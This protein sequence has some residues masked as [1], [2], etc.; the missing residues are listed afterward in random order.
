MRRLV[1]IISLLTAMF[2]MIVPL[3]AEGKDENVYVIPI[4]DEIEKALHV[5]LERAINEAEQNEADVIVFDVKTP[6]GEISAAMDIGQLIRNTDIKTVTFVN[7]RAISAG[8]YIALNTDEIYMTPS[9]VMGAAAPIKSDGSTADKKAVSMWLAAMEGAAKLNDRDP[10]YAKAMVIKDVDLPELKKKDDLLTL[11][12][13]AAE[14]VGYS[15]GTFNN[16]DDLLTHLGYDQASIQTVNLTFAEKLARFIANP[17][18][19]PILLSIAS[20]GLVV[21]LYSPGFGIAGG[22]GLSALILFFF[23]HY[24]AGVAGYEAIILFV[25]GV[26]LIIAEAFLPGGVAGLLGAAAVIGSIIMAGGNIA[27]YAT[28]VVIALFLTSIFIIIM[29]K[30]FGKRMNF[31]KRFILTDATDTESGYVSNVNRTELLNQEGIT[32]TALRP[33]GT[34]KIGDEHLDVVAESGFVEKDVTV[35]VI[36]VEGS[37][38]VVREK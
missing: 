4:E 22:M 5:F 1:T 38:I 13:K 34:V 25:F 24:V 36:K 23:G 30:V 11:D 3:Y 7:N 37:R 12:S 9:A 18:V 8:S 28:A 26:G 33:A 35:K 31:F 2:L 21:E 15:E 19:V 10:M 27:Y 17:I 32:L 29:V 16:L 20:I 14:Q 6:G